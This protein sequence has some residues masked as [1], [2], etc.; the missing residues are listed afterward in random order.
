[1]PVI[2]DAFLG[3]DLNCPSAYVAVLNHMGLQCDQNTPTTVLEDIMRAIRPD[4]DVR[5]FGEELSGLH[6]E[7]MEKYGKPSHAPKTERQ[8]YASKQ[9][10]LRAARQKQR[11]KVLRLCIFNE[12]EALKF[13]RES[14]TIHVP[15]VFD[16]GENEHGGFYLKTRLY[17]SAVPV[18]DIPPPLVTSYDKRSNWPVKRS[19]TAKFGPNNILVDKNTL[20]TKVVIDWENVGYYPLECDPFWDV[21]RAGYYRLYD[22][23]DVPDMKP[24]KKTTGDCSS[25]RRATRKSAMIDPTVHA[26]IQQL[27][28]EA[29]KAHI[30]T[31][32]SQNQNPRPMGI[33]LIRPPENCEKREPHPFVYTPLPTP[34]CI[35]LLR[36]EPVSIQDKFDIYRTFHCTLVVKDLDD[37]ESPVYDALSYTWGN[38]VTVYANQSDVSSDEAWASPAWDITCDGKPFSVTTNLYTA[39]LGLRVYASMERDQFPHVIITSNDTASTQHYYHEMP[40]EVP[41]H[42]GP[43]YI[44]IDQ[45]CINQ[46]DLNE[47]SAQVQLMGQ[48]YTQA[49]KTIIWLGG[50]DCFTHPGITAMNKLAS[51]DP[52]V[53]RKLGFEKNILTPK[54]YKI[55]QVEPIGAHEWI[56]L[57]ALLSRSWFRRSWVVQEVTLCKKLT[58]CCGAFILT[59]PV[60]CL[61]V[62]N[63]IQSTW[64]ACMEM[65]VE[66]VHGRSTAFQAEVEC[67]KKQTRGLE[68][69]QTNPE[70]SPN[71]QLIRQ[72]VGLRTGQLGFQDEH[73]GMRSIDKPERYG[74]GEVLMQFR[75]TRATNPR[76][77]IYAFLGLSEVLGQ[78]GKLSLIPDYNKTVN[79]V[80]M[81]AMRLLLLSSSN[82]P[83]YLALK[84]DPSL[85]KLASLPSWVPDFT[86]ASHVRLHSHIVATPWSAGGP[87]DSGHMLSFLPGNVLEIRGV[88]VG[89]VCAIYDFKGFP[90]LGTEEGDQSLLHLLRALPMF[91]KIRNPKM[92][93]SLQTYLQIHNQGL[94]EDIL[95]EVS[96]PG[97]GKITYQSRLEVFWRTLVL[98]CFGTQYPSSDSGTDLFLDIWQR[99]NDAKIIAKFLK[100]PLLNSVHT[101]TPGVPWSDHDRG[102]LKSSMCRIHTM[103]LLLKGHKVVDMDW[104]DDFLMET[105][106]VLPELDSGWAEELQKETNEVNLLGGMLMARQ[107]VQ[108]PHEPIKEGE[109]ALCIGFNCHRKRVFAT[110]GGHLGLGTKSVKEG[111]EAWILEGADTPFVLRPRKDGKYKLI[112]EAYVHGVM[113]GELAVQG[114][115]MRNVLLA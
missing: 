7:L 12:A 89:E 40:H 107:F 65:L 90:D 22:D 27:F 17:P 100:I 42:A 70:D 1:M 34:T 16:V 103:H 41:E 29:E 49:Q 58:I 91:S 5:L 55:A 111:D 20:E 92:T 80:F 37:S 47:R 78:T 9:N 18:S 82:G 97:E 11:R 63:L 2:Q 72:I 88:R 64:M 48:I 98:D 53:A 61:A 36:I 56:A 81:D 73:Y 3:R 25:Y 102:K 57:H 83:S 52:A 77:K 75:E 108:K 86:V 76:D 106:P 67:I 26:I 38:P 66:T 51:I 84:E 104:D 46:S 10:E 32:G 96:I 50:E 23:K 99:Y 71:P 33:P 45:I 60:I 114:V 95:H 94:Y 31:T 8:A 101:Q 110:K 28:R 13:I 24:N 4:R 112:G 30:A 85:T 109:F 59:L 6:K 15:E 35:R 44:W 14:R 43:M 87:L 105:K 39:L 68:H 113:H 93:P 21:S 69:Y 79:E 115:S 74:L 19:K 62:D 54:P